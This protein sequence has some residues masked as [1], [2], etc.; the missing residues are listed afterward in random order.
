MVGL[1][2]LKKKIR[3]IPQYKV[4]LYKCDFYLPDLKVVLEIDGEI[5]H[6]EDRKQY[7]AD[8]DAAI[9]DSLGEGTEVIRIKASLI[10]KNVT[11]VTKAIYAVLKHRSKIDS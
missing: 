1:Q 4:N 7:E 3:F 10:N 8:R 6:T 9:T 11:R 2:L 5:F